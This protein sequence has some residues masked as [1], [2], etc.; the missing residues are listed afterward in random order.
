[1]RNASQS[2]AQNVLFPAPGNPDQ[3]S[4]DET[5]V[6]RMTLFRLKSL[7]TWRKDDVR[8]KFDFIVNYTI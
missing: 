6:I 4:A 8:G 2:S 1:M 3:Y 5:I 7:Q